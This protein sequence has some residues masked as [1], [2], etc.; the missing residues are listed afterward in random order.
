M[1]NI[2]SIQTL[3]TRL[4][5]DSNCIITAELIEIK[6]NWATIF[7]DNKLV[8]RKIKTSYDGTKYILP[9]GYYSMCP[10]FEI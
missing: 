4:I 9:Y 1:N 2:K 8:R 6:N 7:F 5:T 10:A 3:K